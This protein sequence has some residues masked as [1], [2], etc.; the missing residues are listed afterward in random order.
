[1]S[2][3]YAYIPSKKCLTFIT[4]SKIHFWYNLWVN[5]CHK[6]KKIKDDFENDFISNRNLVTILYTVCFPLKFVKN[7]NIPNSSFSSLFN[8]FSYT[9]YVFITGTTALYTFLGMHPSIQSNMYS[10]DSF[11]ELQFF[12]GNNYLNGIDWYVYL[13]Q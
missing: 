9:C 7:I 3:H 11:E 2:N 10:K 1:M 4:H 13:L 12:N 6:S 5:K 8:I